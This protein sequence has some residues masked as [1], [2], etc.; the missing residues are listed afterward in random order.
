MTLPTQPADANTNGRNAKNAI[1]FIPVWTPRLRSHPAGSGKHRFQGLA[2]VASALS[3]VNGRDPAA[4]SPRDPEA[5]NAPTAKTGPRN[6]GHRMLD[7]R[8][9]ILGPSLSFIP[10]AP[11]DS[12][13]EVLFT[14]P[15]PALVRRGSR[16]VGSVAA[17]G[18][19]QHTP[20]CSS[21]AEIRTSSPV[22]SSRA[23]ARSGTNA[24]PLPMA[25][26]RLMAS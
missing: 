4:A 13:T 16:G 17:G 20:N 11:P 26:K 15:A 25:T 10:P 8:R 24:T 18:T 9:L 22:S 1:F 14:R 12:E 21:S 3:I 5:L 2:P 7:P 23:T 6:P 19:V